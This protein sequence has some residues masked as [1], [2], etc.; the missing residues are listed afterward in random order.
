VLADEVEQTRLLLEGREKLEAARPRRLA[1]LA[2]PSDIAALGR[3]LL[4]APLRRGLRFARLRC[5][6]RFARLRCGLRFRDDLVAR[7]VF[8]RR[9]ASAG[10]QEDARDGDRPQRRNEEPWEQSRRGGARE[11]GAR[12]AILGGGPHRGPHLGRTGRA[13]APQSEGG[14]DREDE[15]E[16]DRESRPRASCRASCHPSTSCEPPLRDP[17]DAGKAP[18]AGWASGY[19]SSPRSAKLPPL[20][21]AAKGDGMAVTPSAAAP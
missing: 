11:R 6:L 10:Q 7:D 3:G 2:G 9:C 5:G 17:P 12:A 8:D 18:E 4:L 1:T 19:R 14:R 13:E 20:R 21:A 16:D 15:Q